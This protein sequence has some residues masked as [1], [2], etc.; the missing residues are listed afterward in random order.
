MGGLSHSIVD[1]RAESSTGIKTIAGKLDGEAL[2]ALMP[3]F[4]C[5]AEWGSLELII[6]HHN[7][8]NL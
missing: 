1:P 3:E 8:P 4:V 5:L 7:S 2:P 6:N